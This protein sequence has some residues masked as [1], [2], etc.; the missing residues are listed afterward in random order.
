MSA[1]IYKQR[2]LHENETVQFFITAN[3]MVLNNVILES[4]SAKNVKNNYCKTIRSFLPAVQFVAG[5]N[6]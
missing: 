6:V 5:L 1:V 3:S 4:H 2:L